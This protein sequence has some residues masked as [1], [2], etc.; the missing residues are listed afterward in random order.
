MARTK[1]ADARGER[2]ALIAVSGGRDSVAL[3]HWLVNAGW[4]KLVVVHVNHALR[5][6]SSDADAKFVRALAKKLGLRCEVKKVDV[7]RLADKK[8]LSIETA[9]RE[10]RREFFRAMARKHRCKYLFTAHHADDQAETVLH[11]LCRGASLAGA[12]GM[13]DVAE[14]IKGIT[15]LRPLL[16]VTRAEIDEYVAAH[17]LKFREDQSN[18]S[19]EHTRNR[20]R[21]DVL[22]LLNDVFKRDVAPLLLRFSELARRDDDALQ[23]LA[24][25]FAETKSIITRNGSLR[26]TADFLALHPA[27]QS[28][29]IHRWLV[30]VCRVPDVGAAEV[31][32]AMELCAAKKGATANLPRGLHLRRGAETLSVEQPAAYM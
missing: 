27:L 21:L 5:G 8:K 11:R 26:V 29:V 12:A 23:Q 13:S 7:A 24:R 16:N 6:R 25:E 30:D 15:T 18:A 32:R 9:G 17:R 22:P 1:S 10:A 4:S 19:R 20:V 28:R 2:R 31:T 14:T 3:L